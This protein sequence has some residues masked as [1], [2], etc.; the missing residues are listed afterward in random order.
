MSNRYVYWRM[1]NGK[2]HL[3]ND[4]KYAP[5][6]LLAE[7]GKLTSI[8]KGGSGGPLIELVQYNTA[9][10]AAAVVLDTAGEELN[11]DDAK[12]IVSAAI[13]SIIKKKGGKCVITSTEVIL[14][15]DE[16]AREHFRKKLNDYVLVTSLSIKSFPFNR[17]KLR[18]CE[19]T[20]LKSRGSRYPLPDAAKNQ[21]ERTRIGNHLK[22]SNY[23]LVRVKTSGRSIHE[24]A[25]NALKALS[26]LRGLRN[27]FATFESWSFSFG[28]PKYQPLGMIHT[29]A[30]HT[31]HNPNGSLVG[32]IFWYEPDYVEDYNLFE[33]RGGWTTIEK[34]RRWSLRKIK[35]LKYRS[36][37]ENFLVRYALALDQ[38]NLDLVF[39][40]LWSI[41]EKL[42]DTDRAKYDKTVERAVWG[43]T[44]RQVAKDLLES[45][46]LRR[47]Q[48]VHA[49]GSGHNK[50]QTAYGIKWIVDL[51]LIH[52]IRNIFNV[53]S[54]EEYG[55]YLEHP[56]DLE[57]LKNRQRQLKRVIRVFKN[58]GKSLPAIS[59]IEL[60][61]TDGV[62]P[63][64]E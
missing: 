63:C 17:I 45:L 7:I 16:Q 13:H 25:E 27:L 1:P 41:L 33:P 10:G 43:F 28:G 24:A 51:H 46:R 6:A 47:N 31:L 59:H 57:T 26:L 4:Q 32:N 42:T 9:I 55:T 23:H 18:N 11:G 53:S 50:D 61:T 58:R 20:P 22:S 30:V 8:S 29:G 21:H 37:L 49:A 39:L 12:S 52:L 44:D 54:L 48:F 60:W 14:E 19:I 5:S 38:S 2:P 3:G 56:T 64:K 34:K 15:A 36:E 40:Q 62:R 35:H